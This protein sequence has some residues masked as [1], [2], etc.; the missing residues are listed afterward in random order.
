MMPEQYLAISYVIVDHAGTRI[1]KAGMFDIDNR[2]VEVFFWSERKRGGKSVLP[3]W[4]NM[5][6]G[7]FF[8]FEELHNQRYSA[9]KEFWLK[10]R[11]RRST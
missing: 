4:E 10:A 7:Q 5:I 11:V 2:E 9:A 1:G 6:I 3:A 8:R